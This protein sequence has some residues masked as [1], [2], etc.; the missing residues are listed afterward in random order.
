MRGFGQEFTDKY[1]ESEEIM[2][3]LL[4]VTNIPFEATEEDIR[5]M[6]TVAGNIK[7][8]KLLTDPKTGKSKGC[9]FVEMATAAEAKEAIVTLDEV[10]MIDRQLTVVEARPFKPQE[11]GS[12]GD[13]RPAKVKRPW[14]GRK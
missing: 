7:S 5:R 4:Y 9:G 8:I 1:Q 6:F 11:Q 2:G 3:K 10:L 13:S 14:M 12:A